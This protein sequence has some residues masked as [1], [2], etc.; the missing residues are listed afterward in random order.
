M[1]NDSAKTHQFTALR[2][3]MNSSETQQSPPAAIDGR[4]RSI[5]RKASPDNETPQKRKRISI[6]QACN[7]PQEDDSVKTVKR[8]ASENGEEPSRKRKRSLDLQETESTSSSVDTVRASFEEK[9]KEKKQLGEGGC[10]S[11]FAGYRKADHLPVAIKHIPKD[12]QFCK[13]TDENGNQLSV[14]VAMM[15][16]LRSAGHS[17]PVS[18]LDWY[19]LDEE[20][21]LVLE[22]PVP[23][24]DL[25]EYIEANRGPLQ[26]EEAKI[27]LKQLLDATV[28]LQEEHI[29][30]RDIK[31]ENIL[32]ETGTDVPRVRLIDFGLSCFFK[33]RSRYSAFYGTTAHVPP[34]WYSSGTYRAGPT[35]VWQLGVVLFDTLHR[36][37]FE[38][39][40]F[41]DD[42]L[43]ISTDLS[44]DCQDFLQLC[45]TKDPKQ[46]STLEELQCHPWLR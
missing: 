33:K 3:N 29:F 41:L 34:E 30:H 11:V 28:K 25:Y 36:S 40:Q 7:T 26:E 46:R 22:R 4:T 35:T 8:K 32:I 17:A 2:R 12:K 39:K 45:L 10:G 5:K 21:I 15:L 16:K 20:L 37:S 19:D 14:E 24:V 43:K 42:Q 44:N 18:M 6:D 23:A 13:Q 27:I 31:V 9:Y 38:T 1:N